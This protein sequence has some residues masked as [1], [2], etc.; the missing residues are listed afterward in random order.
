MGRGGGTERNLC[1]FFFLKLSLEEFCV[2]MAPP[3][4]CSVTLMWVSASCPLPCFCHQFPQFILF[5]NHPGELYRPTKAFKV[6]GKTNH[7]KT[8]L[9]NHPPPLPSA[10]VPLPLPGP[11]RQPISCCSS[12]HW[13][14]GRGTEGGGPGESPRGDLPSARTQSTQTLLLAQHRSNKYRDCN[15]CRCFGV[16]TEG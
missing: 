12:W 8:P 4:F 10:Q 16:Q 14:L 5:R 3:C 11:V 2:E 13:A 7:V 15:L 6:N 9:S 1:D